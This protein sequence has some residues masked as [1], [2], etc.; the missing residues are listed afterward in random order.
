VPLTSRPDSR[1]ATPVLR[2]AVAAGRLGLL[3]T[4]YAVRAQS[5]AT[6]PA[7]L[8]S[9]NRISGRIGPDGT[10]EQ[11]TVGGLASGNLKE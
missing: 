8:A 10:A 7:P 3:A 1:C 2:S 6:L 4:C 9:G 5:V 11:L